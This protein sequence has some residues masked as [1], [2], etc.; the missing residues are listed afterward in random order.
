MATEAG[1]AY[2]KFILDLT[3]LRRSIQ[4][5]KREVAGLREYAEAP[6]NVKLQ[7][8]VDQTEIGAMA[9]SVRKQVEAKFGDAI[10]VPV[11]LRVREEHGG[12]T[13]RPQQ[14]QREAADRARG[15]AAPPRSA[16][17][18][19]VEQAINAAQQQTSTARSQEAALHAERLDTLRRDLRAAEEA[20]AHQQAIV[21][22]R[23]TEAERL[24]AL[25]AETYDQHVQAQ[26]AQHYAQLMSADTERLRDNWLKMQQE[27][28]RIEAELRA[29][30]PDQMFP[31]FTPE[32]QQ[33]LD[34]AI[35]AEV[36]A[37]QE[38]QARTDA[39]LPTGMDLQR[40]FSDTKRANLEALKLAQRADEEYAAAR[41]ELTQVSKRVADSTKAVREAE[42]GSGFAAEQATRERDEAQLAAAVHAERAAALKAEMDAAT[43]ARFAA[44]DKARA[45]YPIGFAD[46]P[47][48]PTEDDGPEF[49]EVRRQIDAL[50]DEANVHSERSVILF[51]QYIEAQERYNAELAKAA[52]ASARLQGLPPIATGPTPQAAATAPVATEQLEALT[53]E[54]E[55]A[56]ARQET[57]RGE[58]EAARGRAQRMAQLEEH[59]EIFE[60][61]AQA[62]D[63]RLQRAMQDRANVEIMRFERFA[64]T[65]LAPD[66]ERT[67]ETILENT[68]EIRQAKNHFQQ[69]TAEADELKAHV[70]RVKKNIRAAET[71]GSD[72]SR[73]QGQLASYQIDLARVQGELRV[74]QERYLSAV[75]DEKLALTEDAQQL[76]GTGREPT[77]TA[78]EDYRARRESLLRRSVEFEEASI[79]ELEAFERRER[80]GRSRGIAGLT[81]DVSDTQTQE[82]VQATNDYNAA[83]QRR[84][85]IYK[86]LTEEFRRTEHLETLS[87]EMRAASQQYRSQAAA[88]AELT[89][90]RARLRHVAESG[91]SSQE[92]E[93]ASNALENTEYLLA[94]R[95]R[96]L[97]AATQRRITELERITRERIGQMYPAQRATVVL[98]NQ[99]LLT[100]ANELIEAEARLADA[101]GRYA[102]M[103]SYRARRYDA[104]AERD[105]QLENEFWETGRAVELAERRVQELMKRRLELIEADIQAPGQRPTWGTAAASRD[106]G[107]QGLRNDAEIARSKAEAARQQLETARA[108]LGSA[109]TNRAAMQEFEAA[110]QQAQADFEAAANRY[111]EAADTAEREAREMAARAAAMRVEAPTTPPSAVGASTP[112]GTGPSADP[113]TEAARSE[114]AGVRASGQAAEAINQVA[115]AKARYV[116]QTNAEIDANIRALRSAKEYGQAITQTQQAIAKARADNDDERAATLAA[117]LVELEQRGADLDSERATQRARLAAATGRYA[118]ANDILAERIAEVGRTTDEGMRLERTR[119]DVGR[120]W[121]QSEYQAADATIRRMVAA[122]KLAEAMEEINRLLTED[123]PTQR[124]PVRQDELRTRGLGI[125]DKAIAQREHLADV[126]TQVTKLEQG[127]QQAIDHTIS[128]MGEVTN[129]EERNLELRQRLATLIDQRNQA[130]DQ[131][132]ISQAKQAAAANDFGGALRILE[133]RF[134][135]AAGYR[136]SE[137]RLINAG[138]ALR[139]QEL[140]ATYAAAD[141]KIREALATR[142]LTEA[143]RLANEARDA[144][145]AG[146]RGDPRRAELDV[147]IADIG[148][149]QHEEMVRNE[150]ATIRTAMAEHRYAEALRIVQAAMRR[151]GQ[152]TTAHLNLRSREIQIL[153]QVERET[154]AMADAEIRAA[155]A[156]GDRAE[157]LR[158][159]NRELDRQ[160]NLPGWLGGGG[161][162]RP[163]GA[164]PTQPP[165]MP[166]GD[167]TPRIQQLQAT[168]AAIREMPTFFSR[169]GAAALRYVGPVAAVTAGYYALTA[170]QRA[171]TDGFRD[172]AY[173][174]QTERALQA[175]F[176]N[177]SRGTE[178]AREAGEWG[179]QFGYTQREMA[180]SVGEAGIILQ[181]STVQTE[182]AF[183]ILER[184]RS[185]APQQN[186]GAAVRSISE[187]QAGQLQSI[188][189][190]FNVPQ[191]FAQYMER[192]IEGGRDALEVLDEVLNQLG[193]TSELT[194]VRTEGLTGTTNVLRRSISDLGVE[195]GEVSAGPLSDLAVWATGFADSTRSIIQVLRNP[196]R[197]DF[198]EMARRAQEELQRTDTNDLVTGQLAAIGAGFRGITDVVTETNREQVRSIGVTIHSVE[199]LRQAAI[200]AQP[201][202]ALA[203]DATPVQRQEAA[204]ASLNNQFNAYIARFNQGQVNAERLVALLQRAQSELGVSDEDVSIGRAAV[205]A[206]AQRFSQLGNSAEGYETRIRDLTATLNAMQ[207]AMGRDP[208]LAEQLSG[209]IVIIAQEIARLEALSPIIITAEIRMQQAQDLTRFASAVSREADQAAQRLRDLRSEY[210]DTMRGLASDLI[211]LNKDY[212]QQVETAE[213][214]FNRRRAQEFLDFF[215]TQRR[216][217]DEF[218]EAQQQSIADRGDQRNAQIAD[219][220]RNTVRAETDFINNERRSRTAFANQQSREILDFDRQAARDAVE[221]ERQQT[222]ARLDFN[223]NAGRQE[224]DFR[225]QLGFE[226]EDRAYAQARKE[227]DRRQEDL[228]DEKQYRDELARMTADYYRETLRN[229][230]DFED[231]YRGL[232]ATG[233]RAEAEVARFRFERD[234]RRRAEDFGRSVS[235][236]GD[237][238]GTSQEERDRQRA[239]EDADE[240]ADFERGRNRQIAEHRRQMDQ[241]RADFEEQQQLA[242]DDRDRQLQIQRDLMEERQRLARDDFEAQL[243]QQRDLFDERQELARGD[244]QRQL[245][246]ADAAFNT[247]YQ[248]R[249][250]QFGKQQQQQTDAFEQSRQRQ[251]EDFQL[252]L[253]KMEEEHNNQLREI[254]R[255]IGEEKSKYTSARTTINKEL[256]DFLK[257]QERLYDLSQK[258]ILRIEE[259]KRAGVEEKEAQTI[260]AM[261]TAL[262]EYRR[263]LG[264]SGAL[265]SSGGYETGLAWAEALAQGILD[266]AQGARDAV[267]SI[268]GSPTIPPWV[269]N[270]PQPQSAGGGVIR[271]NNTANDP[272]PATSAVTN[273]FGPGA[274]VSDTFDAARPGTTGTHQGLDI[275]MKEGTPVRAP[276]DLEIIVVGPGRNAWQG[277][278]IIGID[279]RGREWYFGHLQGS[280]LRPG[281]RITKGTVM[282]FIGDA[283]HVHVQLKPSSGQGVMPTDPSAALNEAAGTTP[284]TG[285]SGGATPTRPPPPTPA[286]G[287][288]GGA[289]RTGQNVYS[290]RR[291]QDVGA[292]TV[293]PVAVPAPKPVVNVQVTVPPVVMDG[294]VVGRLAAPHAVQ[295]VFDDFS[296]A[297][298]IRESSD[299][300]PLQQGSFRKAR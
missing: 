202:L 143:M 300:A 246:E 1:S 281:Q 128:Q 234:Q 170:A 167:Q 40:Q 63:A 181:T 94:E 99:E 57:A 84:A 284:A 77:R 86:Q 224:E 282:G 254:D 139:E 21:A 119:L 236:R 198:L 197:F 120:A 123:A 68:P 223:R 51:E 10:E 85:F 183:D 117:R 291:T 97:A 177:M 83:V 216:A 226:D 288:Q 145:P 109:E 168:Q 201:A 104:G 275:A 140:K 75:R 159:V 49:E 283:R 48:R 190:V 208:Q 88:V 96:E 67:V 95:Q 204:V 126:T 163:P 148:R 259:L 182:R 142:D 220:D 267:S 235:E 258:E 250:E 132:A 112:T 271:D 176:N 247:Q 114:M 150:R 20:Y 115:G 153:H 265:I 244:F 191:R 172:T 285:V 215:D 266:A 175:L 242:R 106:T 122:G 262:G 268:G 249:G 293:M 147:T 78:I 193:Q 248:R 299:R 14:T 149:R 277:N 37:L 237:Q 92:V 289:T 256:E 98:E 180:E 3:E 270:A 194:R 69:L 189:R 156:S 243:Q 141:A 230:E 214:E 125:W 42:V 173:I 76:I 56:K 93:E 135:R 45:L 72:T 155:R 221:F 25:A 206:S 178:A 31:T 241:A 146:T 12:T 298:D 255:R 239:Q 102:Q 279:K 11:I 219:F 79:A 124:D 111:K 257:E 47:F 54:Q 210:G 26:E 260:A 34:A 60:R 35:A 187:L 294:Q 4:D 152:E 296:V 218:M 165:M 39:A 264:E 53:I 73:Q 292:Q 32:Q 261:E 103:A 127:L 2:A 118:E 52:A 253:G 169:A 269:R 278:I 212:Q 225:R 205:D 59:Y 144:A 28:A 116:G 108:E 131:S 129:S 65:E 222:R 251:S 174:E 105:E 297:V 192:E 62:L 200:E 161:G 71:R 295:H 184:L 19:P 188:E 211:D 240:Q 233:R 7:F 203:F 272:R 130:E 38:F 100:T 287:V 166:A 286:T 18:T 17:P 87:D 44:E 16:A 171:V 107:V 66:V 217:Y 160:R 162:G 157:A 227:R 29:Q 185:R 8:A 55:A 30:H 64:S 90:D 22:A 121:T 273:L 61:E 91:A 70:A 231:E 41:R 213:R 82:L 5:A 209:D 158:L 263:V 81:D 274:R 43:A 50:D 195:A 229:R 199:S 252:Q 133:E 23:Q 164:P 280:R 15:A 27:T 89:N 232:L 58:L 154:R 196:G 186:F 13:R 80:A 228:R 110:M 136:D 101:Q 151:S 290:G 33:R 137:Q 238:R 138:V 9:A 113:I 207:A 6:V 36:A 134:T 276:V 46:Q 74:A 24:R 245:E 179:A